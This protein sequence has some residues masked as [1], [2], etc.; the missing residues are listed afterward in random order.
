MGGRNTN[1][2]GVDNGV[3]TL[4]RDGGQTAHNKVAACFGEGEK[5][6]KRKWRPHLRLGR[7]GRF[8]KY[9]EA[10]SLKK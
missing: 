10:L 2:A 3:N 7:R 1:L 6:E 4:V 5:R 9:W 8:V